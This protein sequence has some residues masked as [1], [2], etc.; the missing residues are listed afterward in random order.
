[1]HK[2]L[3]SAMAAIVAVP[4]SAYDY[5]R[6]FNA[7][8][9]RPARVQAPRQLTYAKAV[10][11]KRKDAGRVPA[12][13]PFARFPESDDF[14]MVTLHAE[15]SAW[16]YDSTGAVKNAAASVVGEDPVTIGDVSFLARLFY[17]DGASN[18]ALATSSAES[19]LWTNHYLAQLAHK[20]LAFD[21]R[22]RAAFLDIY[23]SRV[24]FRDISA[25]SVHLPLVLRSNKCEMMHQFTPEENEMLYDLAG[26]PIG[27]DDPNNFFAKYPAGM[28][29]F[30]NELLKHKNFSTRS[31]NMRI[32]IGDIAL[33][34]NILCES[35]HWDFGI[36]GVGVIMP[37]AKTPDKQFMW[38]AWQGNGG[39]W[40]LGVHGG[41]SWRE[42]RMFNP[43]FFADA[44]LRFLASIESRVSEIITGSAIETDD[45]YL[46]PLDLPLVE[47]QYHF[48]TS[49]VTNESIIPALAHDIRQLDLRK[50]HQL[51]MRIGNV[52]D[53][54]FF[55]QAFFDVYY[56][57]MFKLED[58][59]GFRYDLPRHD[60]A[61]VL[62]HTDQL[63]H[64]FGFTYVF[65]HSRGIRLEAGA[66]HRFA[67]S[68]ILRT[69][70]FHSSIQFNF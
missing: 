37:T 58:S 69:S 38:P 70:E 66:S 64:L 41:L 61:A 7:T 4:L 2:L 28:S 16:M 55:D 45:D 18:A 47:R 53:D 1:M 49:T 12:W 67:G 57:F 8:V 48:V 23:Y 19:S 20:E 65:Q 63:S 32:G 52:M 51:T 21:A 68:N 30:F 44:R 24:F 29:D 31:D 34:L 13:P 6:P 35:D 15:D 25:L 39:Y 40:E 10:T 5:S 59:L 56:E 33:R 17:N 36:L 62:H 11:A 22:T 54:V 50:G 26:A 3:F 60:A 42:W 14:A 46:L 9:Q 43:Y 27:D